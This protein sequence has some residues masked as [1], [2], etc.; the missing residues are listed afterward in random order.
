M[1]MAGNP[2]DYILVFGGI[3]QEFLTGI[4]TNSGIYKLKTTLNDFWTYNVRNKKW[5]PI[6]PNSLV[7]PGPTE[8]GTFL[9]LKL[10]R[11]LLLYGGFYGEVLRDELWL[12]NINNNLW[13][14]TIIAD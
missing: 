9:P 11:M 2:T 10:D 8:W 1:V 6:Y 5:E 13:Q 7:N 12:Y 4:D 14:K 3:S